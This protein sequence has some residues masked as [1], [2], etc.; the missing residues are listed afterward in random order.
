MLTV[1]GLMPPAPPEAQAQTPMPSEVYRWLTSAPTDQLAADP[2]LVPTGMGA[3]F[4]PA[5][6]DGASEPAALVFREGERVASGRNGSRIVLEPGSYT[7]RVGSGPRS[8][9]ASVPVEIAAG[10]TTVVP[11]RWGGLRVEVVD[12]SN[13]PHRA[14]Y[15]LIRVADRQPYAVGFGA[16]ILSGERLLTILLPPGL[17]RIVRSGSTYRARTDFATVLV[18]EGSLVHYRLVIN[19]ESGLFRGAGVVTPEEFGVV[20]EESPWNRRYTIGFAAPVTSTS[21]FFGEPDET[22]IT[23]ES[24]F[25]TYVTYQRGRRLF[26]GL[27]EFESGFER[28]KPRDLPAGPW[29]KNRDRLRTDLLYAWS[30]RPRLGLY[31]RLGLRT[32]VFETNTVASEDIVVRRLFLD[33]REERESVAANTTF[34]TGDPFSPPVIQEGGG[35]NLRLFQARSVRLEWRVGLGFRQNRF[36]G[37]FFPDDD[38]KTPEVEYRQAANFNTAGVEAAMVGT[39]RFRFLLYSTTLDLFR[40]FRGSAPTIDWRSTL[41]WRV[42]EDL[43]L[44]YRL[45]LLRVP[46]VSDL[47]QVA[48]SVILR[49]AIGS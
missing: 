16:D 33:G 28:V 47:T 19:P 26:R 48:Q 41:S 27:L 45:D 20:T 40:E 10:R 2:T 39:M 14:G 12:E 4:V 35:L 22:K 13:L 25:D 8:Q 24:Y 11:V 21:N 7:V 44:D 23:V 18:P 17:Y 43:S 32:S 29:R 42:T 34:E 36:A 38:P 3:L 37:A 49:F 46:Q 1:V 6:T 15:E 30:L 5:M 9:M 31:G